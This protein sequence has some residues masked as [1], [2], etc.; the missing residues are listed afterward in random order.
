MII[1]I[2]VVYIYL[3]DVCLLVNAHF[4]LSSEIPGAHMV[5]PSLSVAI[6]NL[7]AP[8]LSE[9]IE[10]VF[11]LGGFS[12]YAVSQP[13]IMTHQLCSHIVFSFRT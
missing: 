7:Q 8:P 1:F 2:L 5:C 9:K 10:S 13:V 6:D 11:I 12:V 4:L 3:R